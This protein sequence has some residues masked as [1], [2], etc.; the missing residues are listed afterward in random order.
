[1]V[2]MHELAHCLQ[3]NHGRDFWKVR[4]QFAGELRELWA[5]EYTGDGLWGRGQTLLSGEY[6][7]AGRTEDE[8]LPARVGGGRCRS[9]RG[10]KRK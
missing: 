5:K 7:E 9:L 1:M 8:V 10:G 2:M 3:M 6:H 4:N